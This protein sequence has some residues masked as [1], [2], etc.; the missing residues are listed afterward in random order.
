MSRLCLVIASTGCGLSCFLLDAG[1]ILPKQSSSE[2]PWRFAGIDA[3]A[4]SLLMGRWNRQAMNPSNAS[5]QGECLS[6]FCFNRTSRC[7]YQHLSTQI[8]DDASITA[9]VTSV[10]QSSKYKMHE[11]DRRGPGIDAD[12][13]SRFAALGREVEACSADLSQEDTGCPVVSLPA[14]NEVWLSDG[15]HVVVVERVCICQV[16]LQGG[17][18]APVSPQ[19]QLGH[20][21][22]LVAGLQ[23]P[24]PSHNY[25]TAV[26]ICCCD[27]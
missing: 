3:K 26:M 16:A 14:D 2:R 13:W 18:K 1:A 4:F 23:D 5:M 20:R 11:S 25:Q 12:I 22:C 17:D 27:A 9:P 8:N 7:I 19:Y 6:P 24:C 10:Q 15:L 21:R